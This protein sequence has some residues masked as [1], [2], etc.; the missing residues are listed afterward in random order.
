METDVLKKE[1]KVSLRRLV[2]GSLM[3]AG[4]TVGAGML[5]I[6]LATGNAG[7]WPAAVITVAVWFF[8]LITGLLYLEVS[9][10]MPAETNIISIASRFLGNKGKI[11]VGLMFAFLYY[12]LMVAYYAAGAPL[13]TSFFHAVFGVD[14]QGGSGYVIFGVI[15]GS[16]V[17]MGVKS[18]DRTNIILT[19]AMIAAY[20]GLIGI[21]SGAVESERLTFY[22]WPAVLFAAPIL[23]S[24][25]G[26]HNILPPL[27]T[28]LKRDRK[29][30]KLSII[31]GTLVPLLIYLLW[32]WL[33]I[34]AIPQENISQ[35]LALGQPAT[36]ALQAA[37]GSHW[38]YLIGQYFGFFAI[39]TSLLE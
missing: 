1:S 10:W 34:G 16:I 39:V 25:F 38:I 26:Y 13:V 3:I 33:I 28:Y 21:G 18:I 19:V 35:A 29:T 6:P 2:S 11:I 9:L 20:I 31:C 15:F 12:C 5:G 14:L 8:M 32:Q 17:A 37:G 27:S 30:L 7:F 23:F 24:A 4:T 36:G 22:H